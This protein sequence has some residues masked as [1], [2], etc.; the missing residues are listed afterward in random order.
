MWSNLTFVFFFQM[1]SDH[2]GY[3]SYSSS[4][5]FTGCAGRLL[6]VNLLVVIRVNFIVIALK[7]KAHLF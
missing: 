3:S 2:L 7:F 6:H 1:E 5:V 4:V